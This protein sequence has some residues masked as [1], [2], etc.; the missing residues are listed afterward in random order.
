MMHVANT[1]TINLTWTGPES[2]PGPRFA[3]P[4]TKR[5][6]KARPR[7][8]HIVITFLSS[9]R[10]EKKASFIHFIIIIIIIII[11]TTTI[12]AIQKEP[13]EVLKYK[14][15]AI[16]IQR[17]CNVKK[18]S[19][20]SNN[21]GDWNHFRVIQKMHEALTRK[22]RNQGTTENTHTHIGRCAHT[23]ESTDVKV[24]NI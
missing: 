10:K 22:V 6:G 11:T 20:T 5:L 15:L 17:M 8:G 3:K 24:Q 23:S 4:S 18:K 7:Y 12:N 2:S 21:S 9:Y 19:D 13:A 16:E 1:S 14:D